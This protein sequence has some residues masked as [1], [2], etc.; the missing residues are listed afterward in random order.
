[1]LCK[2]DKPSIII[3][4]IYVEISLGICAIF[5]HLKHAQTPLW[6]T[7]IY[8][9]TNYLSMTPNVATIS[10]AVVLTRVQVYSHTSRGHKTGTRSMQPTVQCY[11]GIPHLRCEAKGGLFPFFRIMDPDPDHGLIHG[12]L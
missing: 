5:K 3:I 11:T 7:Y 12:F 2:S 10:A 9:T 1:M 6:G 4:I 8:G